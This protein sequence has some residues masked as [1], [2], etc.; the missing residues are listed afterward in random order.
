MKTKTEALKLSLPLFIKK[1]FFINFVIGDVELTEFYTFPAMLQE[2]DMF[3][4]ALTASTKSKEP[5]KRKRKTSSSSIKDGPTDAKKQE[6]TFDPAKE[7]NS[8]P[9]S[10]LANSQS[11]DKSPV[12][13]KPEFK[14]S[15]LSLQIVFLNNLIFLNN[16][17]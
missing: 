12:V 17:F 3:M 13:V 1:L 11:D 8:P 16:I 10:P 2:S 9:S 4:D 6:T 5:R 15:L 14:V 7:V